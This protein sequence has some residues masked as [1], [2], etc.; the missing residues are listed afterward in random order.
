RLRGEACGAGIGNRLL[1]VEEWHD[2]F[3]SGVRL[4]SVG[5]AVAPPPSRSLSLSGLP[6]LGKR[7]VSLP[8]PTCRIV[9]GNPGVKERGNAGGCA[10]GGPIREAVTDER[11]GV[12]RMSPQLTD[13]LDGV[14]RSLLGLYG[15]GQPVGN[16]PAA[17]AAMVP[18][19]NG[20][21]G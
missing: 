4:C 16:S 17:V 19:L 18:G 2:R 12:G 14:L 8:G 3:A 5:H 11:W 13:N 6:R 10:N 21:A 9:G 20:H 7:S 15:T 1:R